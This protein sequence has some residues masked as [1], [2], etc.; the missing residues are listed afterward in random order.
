M[1]ALV[2]NI[3][4][5]SPPLLIFPFSNLCVKIQSPFFE[6]TATSSKCYRFNTIYISFTHHILGVYMRENINCLHRLSATIPHMR[7]KIS[8]LG[9]D[10]KDADNNCICIPYI[11][12]YITYQYVIFRQFMFFML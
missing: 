5:L 6:S 10:D 9:Y 11:Y 2:T 12:I 3:T 8:V 4:L 7:M 1:H